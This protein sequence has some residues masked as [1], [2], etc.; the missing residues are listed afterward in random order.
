MRKLLIPAAG[1]GSRATAAESD[2]PKPLVTLGDLPAISRIIDLYPADWQI[3]IGVGY[4]AAIVVDAIRALYGGS[5]RMDR[6]EFIETNSWEEENSGLSQTILACREALGE[7]PFVFHAVDSIILDPSL[8]ELWYLAECDTLVTGFPLVAGRYRYLSEDKQKQ[9]IWEKGSSEG[10]NGEVYVGIASII[11][12]ANFWRLLSQWSSLYPEDGETLGLSPG[13]SNVVQLPKNEWID[14][15]TIVGIHRARELFQSEAHILHKPAEALWFRGDQVVKVHT[16]SNF[17]H[18]RVERSRKLLPY[19][20]EIISSNRYTFTYKYAEGKPISETAELN[21]QIYQELYSWLEDFWSQETFQEQIDET[22]IGTMNYE[23]FYRSKTMERID[24]LV[25]RYPEVANIVMIND[26]KVKSINEILDEIDWRSLCIPL[27]GRVHGDLHS[28]NIVVSNSGKF[29]LLDWRQDMAGSVGALGD[30]YYDLA[31]L[32]HGF[33]LDHKQIVLGNYS[34][35]VDSQGIA[36]YSLE[37]PMGKL[38]A[39]RDFD[40]RFTQSGWDMKKVQTLEGLIYL[41]V[42]CLHDPREY[43]LLLAMLGIE[44]LSNIGGAPFN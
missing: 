38:A 39:K 16:D 27:I 37:V 4:K 14:I 22:E 41:N 3:V 30:I 42:A 43:S 31:K 36:R 10:I 29:T 8:A 18:G 33:R 2:L 7:D 20:P 44:T 9:I 17:I 15:G 21:P 12:T 13:V 11:D 32:S 6:I 24:C 40:L 19:V 1:R 26:A 5:Q 28:E 34:A 35:D 25:S 23:N